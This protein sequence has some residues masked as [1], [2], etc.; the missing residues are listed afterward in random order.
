MV[1]ALAAVSLPDLAAAPPP[2]LWG[3]DDGFLPVDIRE[4][5][6]LYFQQHLPMNWRIGDPEATRE[7][8]RLRLFVDN[9][10]GGNPVAAARTL[11]PPPD[12]VIW[13]H[14]EQMTIMPFHHQ[15]FWA[16]VECR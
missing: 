5:V 8:V 10:W 4:E 2:P 3:S 11:C 13:Q 12:H 16:S 14:I 15:Q 1:A 6:R 9:A 7:G